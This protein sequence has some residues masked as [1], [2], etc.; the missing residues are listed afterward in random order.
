MAVFAGGTLRNQPTIERS[1]V[2]GDDIKIIPDEVSAG[3]FT[4]SAHVGLEA[5]VGHGVR[6]LAMIFAAHGTDTLSLPPTVALALTW[7]LDFNA[8][9]Q[10]LPHD[11][12]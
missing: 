7:G 1:G 11:P 9:A 8:A 12:W 3:S 2:E 4:A 6:I 5:Q 10:H